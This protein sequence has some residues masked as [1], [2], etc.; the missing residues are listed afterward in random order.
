MWPPHNAQLIPLFLNGKDLEWNATA[1]S[2]PSGSVSYHSHLR[3]VENSSVNFDYRFSTR[4]EITGDMCLK[5]YIQAKQ[6]P[7]ADIF[8]AVKKLDENG[9]EVKFYNQSQRP[10]ASAAHGWR[11]CLHHAF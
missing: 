9:N 3:N 4:T 1:A 10:E 6:F 2:I 8:V 11:E 5:L 7:D